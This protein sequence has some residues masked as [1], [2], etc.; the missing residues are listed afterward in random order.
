MGILNLTPTSF[1]RHGPAIK[2]NKD[3]PIKLEICLHELYLT[4]PSWFILSS[5]SIAR[6]L[7][8]SD[9]TCPHD[10]VLPNRGA[11]LNCNVFWGCN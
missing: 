1:T 6:V 4:T 7:A 11:V 8:S 10:A 3:G 2:P 5:V 9:A